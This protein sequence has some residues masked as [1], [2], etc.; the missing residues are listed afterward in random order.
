MLSHRHWTTF[1][2]LLFFFTTACR[3][4]QGYDYGNDT[5][6]ENF[7]PRNLEV[8]TGPGSGTGNLVSHKLRIVA[9][10]DVHGDFERFLTILEHLDVVNQDGQ[11]SGNV[12]VFVQVGDVMDR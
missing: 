9:V 2:L 3:G 6:V 10:G 1:I 12:D 4:Y 5:S 7:D 11:W 8:R